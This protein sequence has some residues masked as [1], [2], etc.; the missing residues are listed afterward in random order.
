MHVTPEDNVRLIE[1]PFTRATSTILRRILQNE[2]PN[3]GTAIR[4]ENEQQDALEYARCEQV[5][6]S[7]TAAPR[8]VLQAFARGLTPQEVSKELGISMKTVAHH[9]TQILDLCREVWSIEPDTHKGYHFL[10]RTFAPYFGNAE[11]TST[12]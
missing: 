7:I 11:Y 1:V 4:L 10:Y 5:V 2:V 6:S 8:R 3:A 12:D 9:K